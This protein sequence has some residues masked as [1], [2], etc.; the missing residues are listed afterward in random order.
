MGIIIDKSILT[1][2]K[3]TLINFNKIAKYKNVY[4][5]AVTAGK[6]LIGV[7]IA[8]TEDIKVRRA[9]FVEYII[10]SLTSIPFDGEIA[11]IYAIISAD[12]VKKGSKFSYVNLMIAA[13]SIKFGYPLL[14]FSKN[15]FNMISGLEIID[16]MDL[17]EQD[18]NVSEKSLI[19]VKAAL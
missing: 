4:I 2:D 15:D 1:H 11:R 14:T 7:Q 5:S 16:A 12:V 19:G 9:A 13:T 17:V 18:N 10:K 3:K 6:L 8:K